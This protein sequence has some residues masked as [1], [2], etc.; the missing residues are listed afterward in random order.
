MAVSQ[1][2]RCRRCGFFSKSSI[3]LPP[4]LFKHSSNLKN[5]NPPTVPSSCLPPKLKSLCVQ[6]KLEKEKVIS[7]CSTILPLNGNTIFPF[8]ASSFGRLIALGLFVFFRI[9]F[10]HAFDGDSCFGGL[11]RFQISASFAPRRFGMRQCLK[12]FAREFGI[13]VVNRPQNT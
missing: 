5:H 1:L 8:G 7:R 2:T 3:F 6:S 4:T 9:I 12:L 10:F 11:V 13:G